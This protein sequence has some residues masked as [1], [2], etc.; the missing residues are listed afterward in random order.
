[1]ILITMQAVSI[2]DEI[3]NLHIFFSPLPTYYFF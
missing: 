1:M 3:S 2:V